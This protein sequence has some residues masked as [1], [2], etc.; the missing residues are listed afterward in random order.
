MKYKLLALDLDGTLLDPYG[1]LTGAVR[2]AV[3]SAQRR[4]LEIV[5]CTGR[6]YRTT[7]PL[8][9]ELGLEGRVVV[10]NGALVKEIATG[11]TLHAHFLQPDLYPDALG[12]L[13]SQGPPLLYVD[14]YEEG[15]DVLTDAIG[16]PHEFQAEYLDDHS[17]HIRRVEDLA[18]ERRDDVIML[19]TM[20]CVETLTQLRAEARERFGERIGTHLIQNKNYRGHILELFSPNSGKWAGL[21][22][23]AQQL[24]IEATEIAAIG[25]DWNDEEILRRAGLGIAMGNAVFEVQ[26]AADQVVRSNAEGGA[27]EAIE[28]VLLAL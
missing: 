5:L 27:A 21:T 25:D 26:A 11:R 12:F 15:F 23:V 7:L 13:R 19:S 8:L 4:G 17:E 9:S 20:G 24:G 18:S 2:E 16:D 6:R 14:T 22:F 10:N 1:K 3:A 28:R